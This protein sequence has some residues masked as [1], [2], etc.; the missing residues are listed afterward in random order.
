VLAKLFTLPALIPHDIAYRKMH[1]A[2][3]SAADA[4]K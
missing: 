4:D 1:A 2:C 3:S